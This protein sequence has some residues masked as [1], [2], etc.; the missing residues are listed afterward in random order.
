MTQ[1][2]RRKLLLAI[3]AVLGAALMAAMAL[4]VTPLDD[5]VSVEPVRRARRAGAAE[6][7]SIGP[8]SEFAVIHQRD[9]R[10]DL[11]DR[12]VTEVQPVVQTGPMPLL[13]LVGTAAEPGDGFA[14]L[15]TQNGE[16]KMIGVG[17]EYEGVTVTAVEAESATVEYLGREVTLNVEKPTEVPSLP[18]RGMLAPRPG[19]RT[20]PRPPAVPIQPSRRVAPRSPQPSPVPMPQQIEQVAPEE[21][22]IDEDEDSLDEQE[23]PEGDAE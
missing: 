3:N 23:Y 1:R 12:P 11:V 5:K 2:D 10:R 16:V 7:R 13:Q 8:L 15:R 6:F 17:E 21:E 14:M 9:L 4:A 22:P 20:P 19:V 18:G